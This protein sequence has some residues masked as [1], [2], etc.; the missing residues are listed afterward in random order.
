MK[1]YTTIRL[2]ASS[3]LLSAVFFIGCTKVLD[4]DDLTAV[5]ETAVWNDVQL[6]KAYVNKLYLDNM[7]G[8]P[9]NSSN[10]DEAGGGGNI[11]YGQ[12]NENS[13][14]YW[15][16]SN[17]RNINILLRDV[18]TGILSLNDQKQMKG[19]ALFFRAWQY[20][21]LVQR[22]GGV[23]LILTVQNQYLDDLKVSRS[24]TSECITQIIKDLDEAASYLPDSWTGA[25]EG[26]ITKG[27]VLAFKGR[28]LLHYASKQFD[29]T[30]SD[31][32]RWTNAYNANKTA[33]DVLIAAGKSLMS[34]LKTLWFVEGNANTEA[35]LVTRYFYPGRTTNRD[36]CKR[37]LDEAQ[38]CTGADQPTLEIVNAFPMKNGLPITDP[39][40]GYNPKAYWLNRDP[41]FYETIA[42][43]GNLWEL[44]GKS[45]RIQWTFL[46]SQQTGQSNTG[47]YCKKALNPA[48]KPNETEIS[49]TD[50]IEIRLAE[51]LL[52]FAESANETGH[53]TEAYDVL[54]T[55]RQRAGIEAGASGLY[56][57]RSGMSK[58]EMRNTILSERRIELSFEGKRAA[59]LRRNRMYA[60]FN[61]TKRKGL[62]VNLIGFDKDKNKFLT[63]Y[64]SGLVDLD[65]NYTT[66]FNDVVKDIDLSNII[67]YKDEYYF[68]AIPKT[69]LEKNANLKQ[70]NGWAGGSF[71]PLQ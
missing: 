67:N 55:I 15:P 48:F 12:L 47:F 65:D 69:H 30:Q 42:Y 58:D 62:I 26:R 20:F 3:L 2:I 70:T 44:S 25:D 17:I 13:I 28:I 11:M 39:A 19:Q 66:Y 34:N 41:R 32:S 22:Y 46:G 63:A 14:D 4:K 18:S 49:G 61:G 31:A 7:P 21:E 60:S 40:S 35:V 10:S 57:L 16:Y 56:G 53:P 51:V 64:S 45:G 24:K 43:N 8:W 27:A 71:D 23:P 33:K 6:A 9:D 54:K 50:W 29:P 68:F 59:D 5:P 1:K 36:A 38:G 37:P 52:N